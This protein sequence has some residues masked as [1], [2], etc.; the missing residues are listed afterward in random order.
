MKSRF[1]TLDEFYKAINVLIDTL[2][3]A[4][5]V[6]DADKLDEISCI[7]WHGPPARNF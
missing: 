4:G 2:N 6:Q 5:F 7:T 3:A 1:K